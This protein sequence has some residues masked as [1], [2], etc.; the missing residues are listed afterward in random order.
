[1]ADARDPTAI[2]EMQNADNV[3]DVRVDPNF[4]TRQMRTL[5]NAVRVAQ[6]IL[7]PRPI[8][9]DGTSTQK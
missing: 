4:R 6:T 8:G 9:R 1:M 2:L 3:A 7:W 5:T